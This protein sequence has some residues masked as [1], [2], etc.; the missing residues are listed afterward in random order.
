MYRIIAEQVASVRQ[1]EKYIVQNY[2]YYDKHHSDHHSFDDLV[3]FDV[4]DVENPEK[5]G[6]DNG[7]YRHDDIDLRKV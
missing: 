6:D 7:D 2:V 4:S 1:N 3:G 5:S